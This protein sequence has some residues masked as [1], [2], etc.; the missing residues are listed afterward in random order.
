MTDI[1]VIEFREFS[2]NIWEKL[3]H[4]VIIL[5]A[6]PKPFYTVQLHNN[7]SK[8][9]ETS[10]YGYNSVTMATNSPSSCHYLPEYFVKYV[11]CAAFTRYLSTSVVM[12]SAHLAAGNDVFIHIW[13]I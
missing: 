5:R 12:T 7:R 3:H 11:L 1:I 4:T 10:Y 2:E 9:H 6:N 8:L 13:N